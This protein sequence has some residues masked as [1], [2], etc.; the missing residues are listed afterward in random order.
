NASAYTGGVLRRGGVTIAVST[1]GRAPALAGLLREGLEAVVPD[2]IETWVRA[3]EWLKERQRAEGVPMGERRPRLLE[4]LNA[5]YARKLDG[6]EL[7]RNGIDS[8]RGRGADPLDERRRRGPRPRRRR[9]RLRGRS[10]RLFRGGGRGPGRHPRHSPWPRRG[11]RGRVRPRRDRLRSGPGF[12]GAA[13]PHRRRPHGARLAG[14]GRN[15]PA[16]PRLVAPH[17]RRRGPRGVDGGRARLD[18]HPRCAGLGAPGRRF[19]R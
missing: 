2:E 12:S 17:A 9:R 18:G 4:A 7:E 14:C 8:A 11:L 16:R 15:A 3:A 6:N 1:E 19:A 13:L 10:R 5:L